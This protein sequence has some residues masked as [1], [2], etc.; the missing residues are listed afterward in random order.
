M[1]ANIMSA[2]AAVIWSMLWAG[3]MRPNHEVF[4]HYRKQN[5]NV[6]VLEVGCLQRGSLWKVGVNGTLPR[7]TLCS[8]GH[9]DRSKNLGIEMKPWR[10][11]RGHQI[12]VCLQRTQSWQWRLMPNINDWLMQ[13]IVKIREHSDRHIV[14]RPHPRQHIKLLPPGCEL[15]LPH[16]ITNSYDD[17]DLLAQLDKTWAVINHNSHPGIQSVIHGIPVFVGRDSLAATVGNLDIAQIENPSMP[18]R[19]TWF[20]DLLWTEFSLDEIQR[21]IPLDHLSFA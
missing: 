1:V 20:N 3:R 16:H 9:V 6:L 19:G 7:S 21:G 13:I 12:L 10:Y 5:K 18:D 11:Q 8:P 15:S 17:F 14:V 2:D 4:E